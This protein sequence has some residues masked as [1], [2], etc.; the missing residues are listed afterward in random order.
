[1]DLW[2]EL[3]LAVVGIAVGRGERLIRLVFNVALVALA[4][5]LILRS[6]Q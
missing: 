4:A 6:L 2:R 3:I 1:M 5:N